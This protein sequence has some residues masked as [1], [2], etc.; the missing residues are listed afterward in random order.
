MQATLFDVKPHTGA[1]LREKGIKKAIKSANK[2]NPEWTQK[3][4][5]AFE[6]YLALFSV[7]HRFTVEEVRSFADLI[8]VPEPPSLRS[9]GSVVRQIRGS[10]RIASDGFAKVKNPK[11]HCTPC[12]KWKIVSE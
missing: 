8:G 9:W 7:G 12:T 3:A 2:K 11:A 10:G 6:K 4:K 5:E 1:E